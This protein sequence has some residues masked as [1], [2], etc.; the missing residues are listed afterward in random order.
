MEIKSIRGTT[1]EPSTDLRNLKFCQVFAS[2]SPSCQDVGL[3]QPLP[4]PSPNT[5][6][7]KY[8]KNWNEDELHQYG[9]IWLSHLS[10]IPMDNEE[11]IN[12]K[13]SQRRVT[14]LTSPFHRL[15]R[16]VWFFLW[17]FVDSW[18]VYFSRSQEINEW[19]CN[20]F[21]AEFSSKLRENFVLATWRNC[22][23]NPHPY[24]WQL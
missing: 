22:K 1:L 8:N 15:M 7:L 21:I 13:E 14:C 20:I 16:Y 11:S 3:I 19:W 24:S 23:S 4:P 9:Y 17:Y 2:S 5:R 12:L 10:S 6:K 18:G